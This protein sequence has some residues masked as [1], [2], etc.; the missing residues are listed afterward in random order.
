LDDSS[1]S[2]FEE[3]ALENIKKARKKLKEKHKNGI[4]LIF[5]H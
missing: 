3:N 4:Y 2:E 1:G 5:F